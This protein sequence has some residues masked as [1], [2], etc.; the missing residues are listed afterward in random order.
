MPIHTDIHFLPIETLVLP[1]SS[2][3]NRNFLYSELPSPSPAHAR[4]LDKLT[5]EVDA[6]LLKVDKRAL[7][8]KRVKEQLGPLA[9]PKPANKVCSAEGHT[10]RSFSFVNGSTDH[11]TIN[12][13]WWQ[14]SVSLSLKFF[15]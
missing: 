3:L 4:A 1:P 7:I 5:A 15:F 12:I 9:E 2:V 13:G 10:F 11:K 6:I 14:M 8:T